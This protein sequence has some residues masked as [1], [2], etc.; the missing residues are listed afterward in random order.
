VALQF[1]YYPDKDVEWRWRLWSK[2]NWDIMADSGEAYRNLQGCLSA[3]N[4][5]KRE[6]A[7]A[8]V[9]RKTT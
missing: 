4:K 8:E 9:V 3:I 6:A 1:E 2:G 7:T 5:I